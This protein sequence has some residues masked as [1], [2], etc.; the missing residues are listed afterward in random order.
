VSKLTERLSKI[1]TLELSD[2][3]NKEKKVEDM[4]NFILV[5]LY[6]TLTKQNKFTD[7]DIT[8]MLEALDVNSTEPNNG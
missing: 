4:K 3:I 5:S 1:D 6:H 7:E 2:K 8:E